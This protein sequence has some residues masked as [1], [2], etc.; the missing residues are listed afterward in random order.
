MGRTKTF[1]ENAVLDEAIAVFRRRGYRNTSMGQI[2]D[3]VGINRISLYRP[4]GGK[5]RL[6][7]MTL[8]HYGPTCRVPGLSQLRAAA[9]PCAA[10]VGMFELAIGAAGKQPYERCLLINT[11]MEFGH[12]GVEIGRVL[13]AA[14]RDLE[15]CFRTAIEGAQRVRDITADVDPVHTA[16]YLLALYLGM[17]VLLRSGAMQPARA[18]AEHV[19]L[20][21]VQV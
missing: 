16:R 4:F 19:R 17:W 2:A 15:A 6:F 21:L 20:L 8:R 18:V 3:R 5:H 7:V 10:L 1:T 12:G 9:A 11:A 14:F 13:D